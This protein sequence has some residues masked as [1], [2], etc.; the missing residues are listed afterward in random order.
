MLLLPVAKL[1]GLLWALPTKGHILARPVMPQVDAN[2]QD[3]TRGPS[4]EKVLEHWN[5]N[6]PGGS[7]LCAQNP[8]RAKKKLLNLIF[9]VYYGKI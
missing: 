2:G 8:S 4:L 7:G 6:K 1:L 9:K 5:A 3:D